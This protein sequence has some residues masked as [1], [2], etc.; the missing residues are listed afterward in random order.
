MVGMAQLLGIAGVDNNEPKLAKTFEKYFAFVTI[1][2]ILTGLFIGDNTT[3]NIHN[4][5]FILDIIMNALR[6]VFILELSI[7]TW[8][9]KK[10]L[11][12]LKTNWLLIIITIS[13]ILLMNNN[14]F[15]FI[16]PLKFL[17][18]FI[19]ILISLPSLEFITRYFYDRKLWSTLASTSVFTIL[20]GLI[21][22]AID[23]QIKTP[24][25][26][27]WW[28]FATVTTIGYGD[29]VPSSIIGRIIGIILAGVGIGIFVALTANF[30][31][32][33]R[34]KEYEKFHDNNLSSDIY[35]STS[36]QETILSKLT[37]IENKLND[38]SQ[39]LA[40]KNNH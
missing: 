31:G 20:F 25:D 12:Y 27:I 18:L 5:K 35:E 40:S 28:A 6:I 33:L 4:K 34:R 9:T 13:F 39:Q 21:V 16:F 24:S 15:I 38:L 1:L 10:K 11:H 8:T 29:I 19:I 23:P 14:V 17:R 37:T 30:L 22:T 7:L 26:G 32:L 3:L 36:N 2:I